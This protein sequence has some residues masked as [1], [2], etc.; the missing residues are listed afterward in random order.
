[1]SALLVSQFITDEERAAL[2]ETAAEYLARG[3]L[4]RNK[5][6]VKRYRKKVFNTQYCTPLVS[7]LAK[8]IAKHMGIE[9]CPVDPYLG[10]IISVIQ[11]GG[12]IQPHRDAQQHYQQT[13]D[14]HLRCNLL[15]Q[16]SHP[17]TRPRIGD[18][19]LRAS[20]GDLWA[21]FASDHVHGTDVIE[22][23]ENRIVYQFGFVVPKDHPLAEMRG[24][25]VTE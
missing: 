14:K 7:D 17:S 5:A 9:D 23:D 12:F 24:Q 16:G 20:E 2:V 3:V 8:R 13:G 19:R 10:W 25:W 15:V 6:G 4:E 18:L 22:G 21:F 1:M 11:P